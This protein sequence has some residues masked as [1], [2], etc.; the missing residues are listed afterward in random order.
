MTIEPAVRRHP[1]PWII[2]GSILLTS[3]LSAGLTLLAVFGTARPGTPPAA[4]TTT[5]ELG[6]APP[7]ATGYRPTPQADRP[8]EGYYRSLLF[9]GIFGLV[10]AFVGVTMVSYRRRMW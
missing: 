7:S 8:P 6:A 2:I 10:I 4:A 9:S 5:A 3:V 1:T